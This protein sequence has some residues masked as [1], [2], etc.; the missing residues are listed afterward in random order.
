MSPLDAIW[1]ISLAALRNK[2]KSPLTEGPLEIVSSGQTGDWRVWR[3]TYT[4]SLALQV[5]LHR[6]GPGGVVCLLL[7]FFRLC[8]NLAFSSVSFLVCS[9]RRAECPSTEA[10]DV[11]WERRGSERESRCDEARRLFSTIGFQLISI[12]TL[13]EQPSEAFNGFC[14]RP[15]CDLGSGSGLK[16][17]TKHKRLHIESDP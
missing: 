11:K 13:S 7:L 15:Q 6:H 5:L 1:A 9:H 12:P 4:F 3:R 16:D 8:K 17:S 2:K 10:E 14:E